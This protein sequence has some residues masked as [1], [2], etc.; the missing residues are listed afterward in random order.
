MNTLVGNENVYQSVSCVTVDR[1]SNVAV[2]YTGT[3]NER[4]S[5][6]L[7]GCSLSLSQQRLP[8][9]AIGQIDRWFD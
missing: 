9:S 1:L 2:K 6:A 8:N 7:E 4:G 3:A 5:T